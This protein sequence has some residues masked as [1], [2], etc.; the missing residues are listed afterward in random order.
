MPR[1]PDRHPGESDDEGIVL[2]N[3]SPGQDPTTAGGIRYVDGSF[4]LK[5]VTGVFNPRTISSPGGTDTQVQFNDGGSTFGG[6]S[7]L[8]YNKTT[9]TLTI[10]GDL[11]VNGGDLTSTSAT[12]NL[13]NSA[14]TTL[15]VGSGATTI[16]M[17]NSSGTNI[18]SGTTKFPNGISGSLTQSGATAG[19]VFFAGTGGVLSQNNSNLFWDNTNV[20]LGIGTTTSD[21]RFNVYTTSANGTDGLRVF[22]GAT[23]S[24]VRIRPAM[25]AGANNNIVQAGDS[26]I[27]FDAGS[28]DSGAFVITPWA[29][30]TSGLRMTSSGDVGIGTASPGTRFHV[31]SGATDEVARFESTG[32]PYISLFDTGVRQ[33]YFYSNAS[34]VELVAENSKPLYLQGATEIRFRTNTSADRMIINS[35]GD[36][37]IG[38]TS[39]DGA[40]LKLYIPDSSGPTVGLLIHSGTLGSVVN[41]GVAYNASTLA[42]FRYSN[43][44]TSLLTIKGIRHTAGSDWTSASTRIQQVTDSTNQAYIDFNPAGSTGLNA[45]AFGT[46]NSERMRIDTNGNVGIVNT[47]PQALLHVG[48]GADAPSIGNTVLHVSAAG[49]TN[50]AI[51]DSTNNVELMNYAYSGGGLIGTATSHSLGIRVGNSTKL[52]LDTSGNATLENGNLIIGTSGKGID[53]SI[54]ASDPS[55]MSNELFDDYEKGTWL[56]A[57]AATSNSWTY[58]ANAGKYTKI[59]NIVHATFTI[60]IN[61]RTGSVNNALSLSGFPYSFN[62][63]D[64]S[65]LIYSTGNLGGSAFLN[66][67][68][69]ASGTSA[70]FVV[71]T[72]AAAAAGANIA[73]SGTIY[74]GSITYRT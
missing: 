19:S 35:S 34:S 12:F 28:V 59:G 20:R 71:S 21:N 14:V 48:D 65:T 52:T 22:G 73:P 64:I 3:V 11:A 42:T 16:N 18:I 9:D 6:D 24:N 37:G 45:M 15:S 2:E 69:S 57:F 33:G 44:N 17:G 68:T 26:G 39:T 60:W 27:I 55:G 31:Y 72:G 5:D 23:T 66:P 74:Y 1:T 49:T 25:S 30:S 32:N 58:T 4:R 62:D 13:L 61:V 63:N 7:G 46:T 38:T 43:G 56:P 51:R 40:R 70:I 10:T 54:T 29:S 67:A 53:F 8:T 50:L 47:A 41:S 36:V